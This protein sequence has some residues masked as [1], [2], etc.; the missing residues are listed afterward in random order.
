MSLDGRRRRDY[1]PSLTEPQ[2]K[3]TRYYAIFPNLFLSLHPDYMM[4][5]TLWPRAVDRTEVICEWSFHPSEMAKP[6]FQANDAVD[7]WDLTNKEDWGVSELS[8][9]GI[10]SR[11]YKPGPYSAREALLHAFDEVVLERERRAKG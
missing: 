4:T 7:F 1:L 11:A 10:S 6:D 2:R 9:A 5:H 3:E 8:Q